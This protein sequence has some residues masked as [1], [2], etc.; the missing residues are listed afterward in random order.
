MNKLVHV[1]IPVFFQLRYNYQSVFLFTTMA[2]A[3]FYMPSPPT[4]IEE[5]IGDIW[6]EG[7]MR[8]LIYVKRMS[9][10]GNAYVKGLAVSDSEAIPLPSSF[11]LTYV[12]D[13][14]VGDTYQNF[15]EEIDAL[16]NGAEYSN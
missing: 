14:W 8:C 7:K 16:D 9:S 4:K 5:M 13:E 1:T 12:P 15:K 3:T 6:E 10:R 11:E 2:A